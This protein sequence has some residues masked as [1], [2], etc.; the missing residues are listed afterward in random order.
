MDALITRRSGPTIQYHIRILDGTNL[1][2]ITGDLLRQ[3]WVSA[4]S[5]MPRPS[6]NRALYDCLRQAILDG[7]LPASSRVPPS[8][9]LSA[10]LELSRNTVMHAYGQ[11]LAEGY[12]RTVTGSGTFVTDVVPDH[13]L[14][15]NATV[16]SRH[17]GRVEPQHKN[18][19]SGRGRELVD[20]ASVSTVQWG[21]FVPGVPDVNEFPFKKFSQ[22]AAKLWRKPRPEL[23]S[24]SSG[25][26]H[27]Q[28]KNELAI[29]LRQARSVICEP[30]QILITEGVHQAVDLIARLLADPLDRVWVEEPGYW[31]IRSVLAINGL[32]VEPVP[33]DEEGLAPQAQQ[34]SPPPKLI[35]VTPSHQYPLGA[36]MSLRRRLALV[37]YASQHSSWIIEDDYDSEFRFSGHPIPSLQGLVPDA[38]VIYIGTFS[39]TLYPGMRLAYVVIP[40]GLV[41][42]FSTAHSELYREG[43]LMSQAT[44]A[45]FLRA[46]HYAAHI[47]RMRLIYA[48]RRAALIAL[49]DK[50][51]GPGWL[52]PYDSN[53]GLHLVLS[54]PNWMNDV[55]VAK[56][57]QGR[58]V[59]VRPLSLYYA[60]NSTESGLL[61]GFAC[62]S[63]REMLEPFKILADC[64]REQHAKKHPIQPQISTR[65]IPIRGT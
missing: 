9:D 55:V 16:E 45:E 15:T 58:G 17:D 38:P 34:H 20:D 51:L 40:K 13:V 14:W 56:E 12:F 19:L 18:H 33:V 3:R 2:S 23:L 63:E 44:L 7:C 36:V 50:W 11:L 48:S 26:G 37:D 35:F 61:L 43:H 52:H 28:L 46:G 31:G 5:E 29:H 59:A 57:A 24:Y 54:L 47:R 30:N 60:G 25:G 39:K 41:S 6:A 65:H 49:V 4:R 62:L 53:A 64:L 22:I 27:P 21:A 42:S 1:R 32:C 10:E 8:R